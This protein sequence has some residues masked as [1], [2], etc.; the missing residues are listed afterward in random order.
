MPNHPQIHASTHIIQE[1][2]SRHQQPSNSARN[3]REIDQKTPPRPSSSATAKY[4]LAHAQ[5][6]NQRPF[7]PFAEAEQRFHP[8]S[9]EARANR[10]ITT[11][12]RPTSRLSIRIGQPAIRIEYPLVRVA[13][14][15]E[16]HRPGPFTHPTHT[17]AREEEEAATDLLI[18]SIHRAKRPYSPLKEKE[19]NHTCL[20]QVPPTTI[21]RQGQR[22]RECGIE[23]QHPREKLPQ[24][25]QLKRRATTR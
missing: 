6:F 14:S 19:T 3:Q 2:S 11:S 12:P 23:D 22:N 24:R 1:A 13:H 5:I 7:H 20:Q 15:D 18:P 9:P 21:H 10:I 25:P 4:A 17:Q 8:P 16:S